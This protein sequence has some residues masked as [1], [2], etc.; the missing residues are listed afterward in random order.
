MRLDKRIY[1][2]RVL[3]NLTSY[4]LGLHNSMTKKIKWTKV[5][6][7]AFFFSLFAFPCDSRPA[8]MSMIH[9]SLVSSHRR[10]YNM[11]KPYPSSSQP[12]V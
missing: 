3:G 6:R 4:A 5:L 1:P 7:Y 11:I 10:T 9:G 12:F 2:V 8:R